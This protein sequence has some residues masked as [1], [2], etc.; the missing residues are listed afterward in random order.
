MTFSPSFS[1][2][3]YSLTSNNGT[4][5]KNK[6][7]L[8]LFL[9]MPSLCFAESLWVT[10]V[11]DTKEKTFRVSF[12]SSKYPNIIY[13]SVFKVHA[14]GSVIATDNKVPLEELKRNLKIFF[15]KSFNKLHSKKLVFFKPIF[16]LHSVIHEVELLAIWENYAVT[17][18]KDWS[19]G[20]SKDLYLY[21]HDK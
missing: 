2:T 6:L 19:G 14:E 1:A 15:P 20:G 21:K 16:S 7:V 9:L 10:S 17:F 11:L 5:M 18:R 3:S 13:G 12:A 4:N 8:L